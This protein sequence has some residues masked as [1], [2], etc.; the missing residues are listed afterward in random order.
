MNSFAEAGQRREIIRP[1]HAQDV[2]YY[3]V[4]PAATPRSGSPFDSLFRSDGRP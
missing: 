1:T 2:Y 3:S 4:R